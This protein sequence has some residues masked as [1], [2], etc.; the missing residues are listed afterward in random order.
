[1]N[2]PDFLKKYKVLLTGFLGAVILSIVQIDATQ[3]LEWQDL[4]VPVIMGIGSYIANNLRG[5]WVSMASIVFAVLIGF[6]QARQQ[7]AQFEFGPVQL[8]SILMQIS[9]L[10]LGYVA[11]PPKP[12]SYEHDPVIQSAKESVSSDSLAEDSGTLGA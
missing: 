9:V 5:Q 8:Q 2:L 10:F 3:G 6:V 4:I 1:M 7:G 11:P 12:R